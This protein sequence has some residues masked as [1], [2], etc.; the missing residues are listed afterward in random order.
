MSRDIQTRE[1]ESQL[2]DMMLELERRR[3][4]AAVGAVVLADATSER[5]SEAGLLPAA[6]TDAPVQESGLPSVE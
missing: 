6:G 3:K 4:E 5:S 2:V 1:F